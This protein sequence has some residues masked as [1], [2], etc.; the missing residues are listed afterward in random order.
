M[1][2]FKFHKKKHTYFF[3][4]SKTEKM[5]AKMNKK[6]KMRKIMRHTAQKLKKKNG[7]KKKDEDWIPTNTSSESDGEEAGNGN[8]A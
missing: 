5:R 2:K 1:K 6:R 7:E 4:A 3:Q 8:D